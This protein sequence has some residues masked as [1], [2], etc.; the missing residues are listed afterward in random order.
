MVP[1]RYFGADSNIRIS[2][3]VSEVELLMGMDRL[4][5]FVEGLRKNATV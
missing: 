2:Y 3:A 4:K 5:R 1:G